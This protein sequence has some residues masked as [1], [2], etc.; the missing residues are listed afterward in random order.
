M[1]QKAKRFTKAW[2]D[3]ENYEMLDFLLCYCATPLMIKE[4]HY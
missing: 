2:Y 4:L 1:F 3:I